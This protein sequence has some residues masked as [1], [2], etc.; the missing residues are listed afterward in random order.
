MK[1]L[2]FG[3]GSIGNHL[4]NASR[5][6][7]WQVTVLDIDPIALKRMRDE[8]YPSRYNEWDESIKLIS[9]I[10]ELSE[11]P[12]LVIIG[13]PPDSHLKLASK[14]LK[15]NPKA[16]L[17][18]K[19][20]CTPS[21]DGLSEL[22]KKIKNSSTRIYVGYNHVLGKASQKIEQLLNLK[23]F[24]DVITIDVEFREHWGGIFA[25]HHWL[26]G[27]SD[28]YLGNYKNGGGATGEHSHAINMWQHL[29]N[30]TSFGKVHKINAYM[31]FV[32]DNNCFYD[33]ISSI[34]LVSEKN[35][36][37]RVIQDVVTK[38]SKKWAR[39]QFEYG[40]IEWDCESN[41]NDSIKYQDKEMQ[42]L[43]VINFPKT[44]PDDFILELEHINSN[45]TSGSFESSPISFEKGYDTMAI[46][47][48]AYK[49]GLQQQ[50]VYLN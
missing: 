10:D 38:P 12:E 30:L 22:K 44:R 29:S 33:R 1:V 23:S 15:L 50:P 3:A 11:N 37:G 35:L 45:L 7:N 46:I 39:I 24:G 21:M 4:A 28:S 27:P 20:L 14:A 41:T 25:A 9:N 26:D 49:S 32:K 40:F 36:I 17:I 8:I 48:G 42:N 16:I 34:N 47:S 19:P 2:I 31:D 6:L 43:E 5:N 18:E 13:T